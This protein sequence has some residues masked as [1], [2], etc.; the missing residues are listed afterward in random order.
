MKEFSQLNEKQKTE[1]QIEWFQKKT[2]DNWNKQKK[3]IR[4][5]S[6][7]FVQ[8]I[9]NNFDKKSLEKLILHMSKKVW[10]MILRRRFNFDLEK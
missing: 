9:R 8:M 3:Q 4:I 6:E 10:V 2:I 5:T 1:H 7:F